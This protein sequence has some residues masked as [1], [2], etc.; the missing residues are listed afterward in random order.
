[1]LILQESGLVFF[2]HLVAQRLGR[3]DFHCRAVLGDIEQQ[4]AVI[5]VWEFKNIGT[6]LI[7]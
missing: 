7:K 1:M 5:R 2:A 4:L 3:E 6:R